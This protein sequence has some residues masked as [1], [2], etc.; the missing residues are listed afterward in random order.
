MIMTSTASRSSASRATPSRALVVSELRSI[1]GYL[2]DNGGK[3]NYSYEKIASLMAVSLCCPVHK[4]DA[5]KFSLGQAH[6]AR[7]PIERMV[8]L[9]SVVRKERNQLER[10]LRGEFNT[11]TLQLP[12]TEISARVF[13]DHEELMG[14]L[15]PAD[16][17]V[18]QAA[19]RDL[20]P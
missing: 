20:K 19:I 2:H 7:V 14:L 4:S 9:L 8:A 5:R 6:F 3:S 10:A 13:R 1:L 12:L 16:A 18:V 17:L 15:S 11:V